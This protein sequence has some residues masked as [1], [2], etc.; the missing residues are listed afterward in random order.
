KI[1]FK[2]ATK[3]V[4]SY[5]LAIFGVLIVSGLLIIIVAACVFIPLIFI[6]GIGNITTF[7]ESFSGLE[8]VG[9]ANIA[10]GS[11]LFALP[12]LAP[13]MVAIGALFG[14]GR[15]IVESEGTS[16]EGVFTWYK[17]KFFSLAGGGLVLFIVVV[18]PLMLALLFGTAIYGDQFLTI[19]VISAGP[20]NFTNPIAISLLLIWLAVSTGLLSMLFPSIIDGYSVFESV[21]RSVKM[22]TKYFDRVFGIW[23]AFLLILAALI[24]PFMVIPFALDLTGPAMM[25]FAGIMVVYA[26]PALLILIFLYLPAVTIGLTRVYMILTA[27]DDYHET[28]EEESG[29]SFIG[30]V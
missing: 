18:G 27:D 20:A 21:K 19:A 7:F 1:S 4:I 2:F 6:I 5:L 17:K 26:I 30:G 11:L 16:A 12:F 14:L 13:F 8:T 25:A 9:I 3:N 29:P 24:V 28:L 10:L 23:M 15:E 22:S